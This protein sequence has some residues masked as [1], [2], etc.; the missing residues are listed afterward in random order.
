MKKASEFIRLS[1]RSPA[2][3]IQRDNID[4]GTKKT[5]KDLNN[6]LDWLKIYSA[7]LTEG[8]TSFKYCSL[9]IPKPS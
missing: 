3:F 7:D 8:L 6:D 9:N 2:S 1:I 4:S 5:R